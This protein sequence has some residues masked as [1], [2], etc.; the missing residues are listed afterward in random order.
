MIT[1]R[2]L[3]SNAKMPTFVNNVFDNVF[4]AVYNVVKLH[5]VNWHVFFYSNLQADDGFSAYILGWEPTF[6]IRKGS[7]SQ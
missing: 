2:L 4:D 6:H 5:G 3:K 7:F 1:V